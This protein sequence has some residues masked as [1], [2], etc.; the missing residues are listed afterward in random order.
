MRHLGAAGPGGA[1]AA[2]GH[3]DRDGTG[4]P[5]RS[6]ST[7]VE[8]HPGARPDRRTRGHC[9]PGPNGPLVILGGT[10]WDDDGVAGVT[11]FAERLDAAGRLL[12]PPP[13]AVRPP[14][15]ELCRRCRH[16]HQP[17][18]RARRSRKPTSCS[19][20]AAALGEMPSSGYT[21]IDSPYPRP[22]AGPRPSRCRRT[23][24]RLPAGACDQR[25]ARHGVR[26]R[27]RRPRARR[28]TPVWAERTKALHA[29]YLGWSTPPAAGPG[30]RAAWGRS[31]PGS[32]RTCPQDAIFTN[33]AG[34]YATWLHRFHRFRQFATQARPDLGLDGLRPA[35]ARSPP[36]SCYPGARGHLLCRRRLLPDER[37]GIRHRRALPTCRSSSSS[38]TTASTARS[39]CTRS[40]NIPAASA[41]TGLTNPDF[42]AF[43]ARLWRPWRDGRQ[44]RGFRARLRARARKRQAGDHR[45]QARSGGDHAGADA[46]ADQGR[47][48]G[49]TSGDR[50][51][52]GRLP[53]DRAVS[54]R[55]CCASG[56][57]C[58][59]SGLRSGSSRA[60]A[61]AVR[62]VHRPSRAPHR[63][64]RPSGR[65]ECDGSPGPVPW[66]A[67]RDRG[68]FRLV[69]AFM[70]RPMAERST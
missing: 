31:W 61:G 33:G 51:S 64:S 68:E 37:P 22:D 62:R 4:A 39:A 27:P 18:A 24:P 12:V 63:R 49:F 45:G 65:P 19:C 3:A 30:R 25:R 38:S 29:A 14:A 8:T 15:P 56:L 54:P 6:P 44:D 41:A 52:T 46:V 48:I 7:P 59:S 17:G 13:D 10:R 40:A 55:R 11:A 26:R 70:V 50:P 57:R 5:R 34:N 28:P 16:R 36:S 58:W 21:L 53:P 20:S 60:S 47:E 42:A 43:A 69:R 23:R 66:R 1:R 9:S 32:K 67:R 35:G 2:R